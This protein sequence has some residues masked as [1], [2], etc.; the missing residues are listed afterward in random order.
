MGEVKDMS[1]DGMKSYRKKHKVKM[2]GRK[3]TKKKKDAR[4]TG[5]ENVYP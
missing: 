5:M 1:E 4:T 2:K 3:S